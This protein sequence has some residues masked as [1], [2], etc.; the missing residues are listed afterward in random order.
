[1]GWYDFFSHFYDGSLEPLY[2]DARREAAAAL[3]LE[4]GQRVLDLPVGTGQSLGVLASPVKPGGRVVGVDLSAGMLKKARARVEAEALG[5]VVELVHASVHDAPLDA[6]PFDRLHVFLGLTA[7]P[8]WEAAFERLWA[9]LAPGGR[10]VV[11]DVYAEKPGFQGHMV[12]LVAR[13]DIRRR[14]WEPL[15]RVAERF[16]R[17]ALPE[18]KEYGGE[19]WLATG[20]KPA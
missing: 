3:R 4:P 5:E 7:F 6:A 15:E 18:K 11:V 9:Q 10:A 2:A 12:N 16:E 19:L 20:V 14:A 1:M 13:A 17:R 8:E